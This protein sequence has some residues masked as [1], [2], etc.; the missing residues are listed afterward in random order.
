M[1]GSCLYFHLFTAIENHAKCSKVYFKLDMPT[2]QKYSM[3]R[4]MSEYSCCPESLGVAD[5]CDFLSDF[6]TLCLRRKF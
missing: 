5:K 2:M 4:L 6:Q 1:I 3:D